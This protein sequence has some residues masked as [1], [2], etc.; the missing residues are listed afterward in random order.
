[1]GRNVA[2]NG[3]KFGMKFSTK[4][5]IPKTYAI[6]TPNSHS[7][8]ATTVATKMPTCLGGKPQRIWR[9]YVGRGGERK[10]FHKNE[11]SNSIAIDFAVSHHCLEPDV[12]P[13]MQVDDSP[14]A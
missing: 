10:H 12:T 14:N 11:L 3:P 5:M 7:I 1:M 4:V 13:D 8:I 2:I 9:L 6:C